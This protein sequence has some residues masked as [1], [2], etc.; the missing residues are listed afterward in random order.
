MK[1]LF[2]LC[3][4]SIIAIAAL[5]VG[6]EQPT[7]LR[8]AIMQAS[9]DDSQRFG[10][11]AEYFKKRGIQASF[12]S[13]PNYSEAAKMFANGS[14]DAMFSGSGLAGT[15]L[16]KELATPAVRPVDKEGISTYRAVVVAPKGASPFT[17]EAE[18]FR[19]KKVIYCALASSG[20]FFY[21][22]LP[23]SAN[24]KAEIL[25]AGNH[26]AAVDTLSRGMA[27]VAIVKNHVW[28]KLQAKYPNLEKIGEDKADNPDGTLILSKKL[29]AAAAS[30][31]T[32]A[33]LAVEGD[34]SAEANTVKEKL[35]V[36]GYIKTS[37]DDFKH[38]LTLL[39]K[40]GVNKSFD[41]TF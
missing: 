7:Q 21:R 39:K 10:A 5:P 18:Y 27:D 31:V 33:L 28:T 26:G 22:A 6:A 41:F 34:S 19:G 32:Q 1:K 4:F 23:G 14:V 20:E 36:K 35:G 24:V 25:K 13:T 37:R 9:A 29:N 17:G 16:I 8:I 12:V 2:V 3:L 11:L 38:T 15:M 30:K 40:A